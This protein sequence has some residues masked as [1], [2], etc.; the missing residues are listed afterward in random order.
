MPAC[1]SDIFSY[2]DAEHEVPMKFQLQMC[3]FDS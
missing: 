2:N 3:Q 1:V